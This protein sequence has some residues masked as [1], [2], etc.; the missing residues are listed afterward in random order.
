MRNTN[1]N[2]VYILIIFFTFLFLSQDVFA[3]KESDLSQLKKYLRCKKCDLSNANLRGV[4]LRGA[5]LIDANLNSSDLS[6]ANLSGANLS[7]TN[8]KKANL[9]GS[10]LRSANLTNAN[11]SGA[12]LSGANLIRVNLSKVNLS[13]A[14]LKKSNLRGAKLMDSNLSNANVSN[15]DLSG[16]K[17]T[18]TNTSDAIFEGVKGNPSLVEKYKEEKQKKLVINQKKVKKKEQSLQKK[19][20]KLTVNELFQ[21]NENKSDTIKEAEEGLFSMYQA[22]LLLKFCYDVRKGEPLVYIKKKKMDEIKSY[23]KKIETK[24]FEE[25]PQLKSSKDKIWK[26]AVGWT[27]F[28]KQESTIEYDEYSVGKKKCD[29]SLIPF[30]QYAKR[31]FSPTGE[32]VEKDF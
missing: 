26:N 13:G 18:G 32:V 3:Y 25:S 7:G 1:S 6:D 5:I 14:N 17:L 9:S 16:A 29:A 12:N 2:L 11:L 20:K 31:F 8:L 15:A 19:G 21:K 28:I 22:Y 24:F 10:V 23:I 27:N 30:M 4:N